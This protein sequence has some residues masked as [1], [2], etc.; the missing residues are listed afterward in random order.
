MGKQFHMGKPSLGNSEKQF[1][2]ERSPTWKNSLTWKSSSTWKEVPHGK[3]V[4]LGKPVSW[5][6]V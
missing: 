4:P 5:K 6:T 1:H 2:K 3:A